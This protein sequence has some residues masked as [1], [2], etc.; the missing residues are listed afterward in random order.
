MRHLWK[1]P[2]RKAAASALLQV[3]RDNFFYGHPRH[4]AAIAAQEQRFFRCIAEHHDAQALAIGASCRGIRRVVD[5]DVNGCGAV[6]PAD[7]LRI[8][9]KGG[10]AI[11]ADV[12][13]ATLRLA[14]VN[15][16][17]PSALRAANDVL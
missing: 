10:A 13:E 4:R 5:D 3:P 12:V 8:D 15:D 14:G 7:L 17:G 6:N 11:G 1:V 9:L 16:L 2:R